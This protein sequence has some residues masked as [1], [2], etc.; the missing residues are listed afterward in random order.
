M[1]GAPEGLIKTVE[2]QTAGY[3]ELRVEFL[4]AKNGLNAGRLREIMAEATR[5]S[6]TAEGNE[7]IKYDFLAT[8][9]ANAIDDIEK[10]GNTGGA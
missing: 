2:L 4:S 7:S 10:T 1:K 5:R 8:N 9:C 6:S 3:D